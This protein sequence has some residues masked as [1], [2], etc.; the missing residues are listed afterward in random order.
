MKITKLSFVP[1]IHVKVTHPMRLVA[2]VLVALAVIIVVLVLLFL[3]TN[4]NDR[5][6]T[7][8]A[9][10][11]EEDRAN[12]TDRVLV[13]RVAEAGKN[14]RP[15]CDGKDASGAI[16]Q[17]VIVSTADGSSS[18]LP[19]TFM[20]PNHVYLVANSNSSAA[21]PS[22]FYLPEN[23]RLGEVL[24][25]SG[26][27]PNASTSVIQIQPL[28]FH[29]MII[30]GTVGQNGR[31]QISFSTQTFITTGMLQNSTDPFGSVTLECTLSGPAAEWTITR[32]T[33]QWILS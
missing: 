23:A 24:R 25:V 2:G 21:F 11:E 5:D 20:I 7:E 26:V 32:Q 6:H 33:G 14:G 4:R 16:V 12:N 15:G 9:F 13:N 31:A 10:E 28:P 17:T 30:D 3:L 22:V 19:A 18:A 27:S 8:R 1:H 29:G